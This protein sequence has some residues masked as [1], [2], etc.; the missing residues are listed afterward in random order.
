MSFLLCI[1]IIPVHAF[2]SDSL[3]I[4]ID[5][6]GDAVANFRFT[7]EGFVENA[8]P[9]SM[10]ESELVKGLTS[11]SDPPQVL[12]FDRGSASLLLKNFAVKNVVPTGIEYQTAS[13][14]FKRAEIALKNSA[15]SSVVSADFSPAKLV[16]KFPDG[17][18]REFTDSSVLPSLKHIIIDPSK[19]GTSAGNSTSGSIAVTSSPAHARVILDGALAGETPSTLPEI[20]PGPHTVSL[21]MDGFLPYSRTV[22]VTAGNTT[23]VNAVL[24]YVTPTPTKPA[25]GFG[26]ICTGIA[27]A[28]CGIVFSR[29]YRR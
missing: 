8:I 16:V 26:W 12:S 22:N 6:S 9:Q 1:L 21:Q 11:S 10:L 24:S 5:T 19:A 7:L 3:D 20:A 4:T 13:M 17:Y 29:R 14:D 23:T 27:L 2:T 25:P 18:T 28:G 15:L